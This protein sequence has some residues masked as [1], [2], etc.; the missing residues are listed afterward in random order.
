M[1]EKENNKQTLISDS[2]ILNALM[3]HITDSI[4]FKDLNSRVIRINKAC[5]DKF[6]INSPD[7]AIGKTDFDFFYKKHALKAY[8]D[9]QRIIK[10]GQPAINIE[11][12]ETNEG[13]KDQWASSTKMPLYNNKGKIIGTFGITRDIT[14]K[15]RAEEKVAYL[16]FHDTLTGL[17]NRAYFEEELLRLNT[18]RQLPLTIV[19]ADVNKLKLINDVYGHLSGDILLK[20]IAEIFKEC[21]RKEDIVSRW[22]GDEYI[23]ILPHT[24]TTNANNIAKR[25]KKIC[26]QR[27]TTEMPLSISIGVSTK[28]SPSD[29]INDVLKE[30][31]SKMYKNKISEYKSN[32]E[33]IIYSL[34]E[35]LRVKDY[36]SE[37]HSNKMKEYAVLIGEKLDLSSVKIEELKLLI[38]LYN[39][40]KLAL[41]DEI[42][43]K[44]RRLTSEEWKI[45][46]QLPEIGYRIA[47]SSEVLKPIAE[48]ILSHYEWYNGQG[49]PRGIKGEEIPILSRISLLINSYDAMTEDRPYRKKMVPKDVIKEIKKCCGTQFDPK[50]AKVFLKI[51]EKDMKN[52]NKT[53]SN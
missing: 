6:G 3:D 36:G 35:R 42:I 31:E 50:I 10:T 24:T 11:E 45:I 53:I 41:A 19:V 39:I 30:A 8:T 26:R 14:D 16:S 52:S 49:Y 9:E 48:S 18:E 17:Y 47:E 25:I 12:N 13:D 43:S 7:D 4:Y 34:K 23:S 22:G 28:K 51:L 1:L 40:G 32:S 2:E 20:K 15:K 21:F 38:D 5:S 46:K 27:S 44:P 33:T 29:N 37:V